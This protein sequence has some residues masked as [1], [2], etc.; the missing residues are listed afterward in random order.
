MCC[1]SMGRSPGVQACDLPAC[2]L[3]LDSTLET[4]GIITVSHGHKLFSQISLSTPMLVKQG[5]GCSELVII[6]SPYQVS[7]LPL[8]CL[9]RKST[10]LEFHCFVNLNSQ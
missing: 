10:H 9:I 4:G 7:Q 5:N 6:E 3:K 1:L 8:Y 2:S